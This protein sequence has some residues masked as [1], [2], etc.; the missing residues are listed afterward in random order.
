MTRRNTVSSV[1][2]MGNFF[3]SG[4]RAKYIKLEAGIG[5]GLLGLSIIGI[6]ILFCIYCC[7]C[8]KKI[9]CCCCCK[10]PKKDHSTN[11]GA[12]CK[13]KSDCISC[14]KKFYEF[15]QSVKYFHRLLGYVFSNVSELYIKHKADDTKTTQVLIISER[16]IP[17]GYIECSTYLYFIYMLLMCGLWFIAIAVEFSL[18]R[19]TGTCNDINAN[20]PSFRCFDV[21][22]NF[23]QIDCK[24]VNDTTRVICY[25]YHPNIAGLGVA[26]SAAKLVSVVGD[27]AFTIILKGTNQCSSKCFGVL[28]ILGMLL[29]SAGLGIFLWSTIT[30]RWDHEYFIYAEIPMRLTQLIL[31]CATILGILLLPPWKA[32]SETEYGTKYRHLGHMYS[33]VESGKEPQDEQPQ[34]TFCKLL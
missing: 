10:T 3:V 17:S 25:L 15:L 4:D 26:F 33:D 27:I 34:G 21:D 18:Y 2:V 29:G 14:C 13:K 22:N 20:V 11:G 5:A 30:R 8:F 1:L 7:C 23:H 16:E 28:C 32:Y 31:L 24:N 19:K 6:T 12:C 9:E